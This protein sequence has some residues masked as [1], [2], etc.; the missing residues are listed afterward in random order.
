VFAF[1]TN[2]LIIITSRAFFHIAE[3]SQG[4][5]PAFLNP[6]ALSEWDQKTGALSNLSL[7]APKMCLCWH[8]SEKCG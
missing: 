2:L 5:C 3:Q 7:S 6:H 8:C 1:E 4:T